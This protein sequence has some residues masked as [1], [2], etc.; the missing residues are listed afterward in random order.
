MCDGCDDAYH[1]SCLRPAIETL[2]EGAWFCHRCEQ[3][4]QVR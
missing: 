1:M 2:P 3:E 4:I